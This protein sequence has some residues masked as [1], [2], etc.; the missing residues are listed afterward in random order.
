MTFDMLDRWD[1]VVAPFPFVDNQNT[2]PRPVLVLS[3]RNFNAANGHIIGTMITTGGNTQWNDDHALQD[4]AIAG[5]RHASLVR[6]KLFTLPV[7]LVTKRIGIIGDVDRGTLA[8]MLA[9]IILS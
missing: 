5:L 6:W 7:S 2:K 8:I 1:E 3:N 4:V 9:R